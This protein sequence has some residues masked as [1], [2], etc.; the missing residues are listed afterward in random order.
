MRIIGILL[1][2]GG[3]ILGYFGYQKMDDNK[4][5]IKIG[6]LEISAK[7]KKGSNDGWIMLGA[8]GIAIIA[9]AV[10]LSRKGS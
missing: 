6:D 9:G 3:L 5:E 10:M 1:I 7:D 2:I 8:G 4:K